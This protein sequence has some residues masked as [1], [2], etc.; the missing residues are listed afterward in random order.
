M[1]CKPI[2]ATCSLNET[3]LAYN[4]ITYHKFS[5]LDEKSQDVR[6][7]PFPFN[8]ETLLHLVIRN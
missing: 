8:Q 3:T 6:N 5:T 2:D 7:S 4:D 1:E